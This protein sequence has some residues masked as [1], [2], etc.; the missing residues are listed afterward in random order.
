[1]GGSRVTRLLGLGGG[2]LVWSLLLAG[3]GCSSEDEP[4]TR[5]NFLF[6]LADD[7]R[8]DTIAAYGNRFIETPHLDRLVFRGFSFRSNYCLGSNSGAGC[9]PSRAMI[10]TGLAYSRIS[11]DLEGVE[12]LPEILRQQGYVTFATGKWHNQRPSFLPAS[13]KPKRSSS[14]E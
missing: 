9:V 5:P 14:V 4:D 7:Q 6:L 12:T 3:A 1:M 8:A 13:V 11:H 2:L 10:H